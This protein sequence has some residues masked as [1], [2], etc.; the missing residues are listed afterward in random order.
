M[1]QAK[2]H[3]SEQKRGLGRKGGKQSAAGEPKKKGAKPRHAAMKSAE[4]LSEARDHKRNN[5]GPSG[6]GTHRGRERAVRSTHA[7]GR[8]DVNSIGDKR[9]RKVKSNKS[10]GPAAK[11]GG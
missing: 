3:R 4:E 5:I 10:R 2:K 1:A 8:P 7:S 9:R 11:L 6:Q